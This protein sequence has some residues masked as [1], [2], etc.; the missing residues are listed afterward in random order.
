M[1][2]FKMVF[3]FNSDLNKIIT[4]SKDDMSSYK[5][6]D[7]LVFNTSATL[8]RYNTYNEL[9]NLYLLNDYCGD[10]LYHEYDDYLIDCLKT[11]IEMY[12]LTNG[13]YNPFIGSLIDINNDFI[14]SVNLDT[15]QSK[16]IAELDKLNNLNP[17]SIIDIT[18]NTIK[19]DKYNNNNVT[20]SLGGIG[21]GYAL[22]KIYEYM[23]ELNISYVC[24]LSNSS[25]CYIGDNKMSKDKKY[26]VS[27]RSPSLV[28]NE[29]TYYNSSNVICT[30]KLDKDT[31]ISCSGDDI[32]R[33]IINNKVYTHII[34]PSTGKSNDFYR[35]IC[36]LS[37]DCKNAVMDALSTAVFNT[38]SINDAK[39]MIENVEEYYQIDI[40][41]LLTTPYQGSLEQY[42][43]YYNSDFSNYISGG[44]DN[45]I[46]NK[47]IL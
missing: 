1:D 10:G 18:N 17:N 30:L 9:N 3:P 40:D 34:D 39:T 14:N 19:F 20:I 2:P 8:D 35:T 43:I 47:T 25:N 46:V 15:Y 28:Y 33:R 31:F 21:K 27:L 16:L 38:K 5:D 29:G 12:N 24:S 11:S 4:F 37:S 22:D 23:K 7:K 26:T 44:F 32:Q 13:L 45:N 42:D 36:L 6:L 41:Y